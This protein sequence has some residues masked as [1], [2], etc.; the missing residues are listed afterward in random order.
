MC[1]VVSATNSGPYLEYELI[2]QTVRERVGISDS[3]TD[4]HKKYAPTKR[5]YGSYCP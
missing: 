5:C 2:M 4:I 3:T 1:F